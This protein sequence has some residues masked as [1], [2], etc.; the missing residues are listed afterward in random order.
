MAV[1]TSVIGKTTSRSGV[2][3]IVNTVACA[4]DTAPAA[5]ASANTGNSSSVRAV[6]IVARACP[7]AKFVFARSHAATRRG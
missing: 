1:D 5:N 3:A 7:D 4:R 6:W 2:A